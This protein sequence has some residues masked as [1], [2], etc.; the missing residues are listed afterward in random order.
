M[1][2]T[3][4]DIRQAIAPALVGV[5]IPTMTSG[6]IRIYDYHKALQILQDTFGVQ[7]QQAW[8]LIYYLNNTYQGGPCVVFAAQE[9]DDPDR[10]PAFTL[11]DSEADDRYL[12][13]NEDD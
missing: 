3:L 5:G 6:R 2:P 11:G 13:E 12:E 10:L 1:L 7:R 8:N 9:N 4:N